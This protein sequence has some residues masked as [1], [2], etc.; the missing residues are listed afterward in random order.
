MQQGGGILPVPGSTVSLTFDTADGAA[1]KW[2]IKGMVVQFAQNI[3]TI[4]DANEP[5]LQGIGRIESVSHNGTADTS[6]VVTTVQSVDGSTT[7]LDNNGQC[8]V[9]G[10]S[11]EQGSGAPDV[12]S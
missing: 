7:T 11:Y 9:I 5:L 2:L 4:G 8:V 1:V 3:N 10:T 12:W 6:I